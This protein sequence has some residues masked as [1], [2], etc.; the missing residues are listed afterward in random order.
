MAR[1]WRIYDPN[2]D[3]G[4]VSNYRYAA[5]NNVGL[6]LDNVSDEEIYKVYVEN[7][8]LPTGQITDWWTLYELATAYG[9]ENHPWFAENK[10]EG[11]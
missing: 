4:I 3:S 9:D 10:P 5:K 2:F 11:A 6:N 8:T 7:A 1:D